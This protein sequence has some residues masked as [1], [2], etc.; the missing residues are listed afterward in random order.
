M[1]G[2]LSG[3]NPNRGQNLGSEH[4]YG[5][6]RAQTPANTILLFSSCSPRF[7][8]DQIHYCFLACDARVSL[9]GP[10]ATRCRPQRGCS[11]R[12]HHAASVIAA[13]R[14]PAARVSRCRPLQGPPKA[15]TQSPSILR[16]P[17]HPRPVSRASVR[18]PRSTTRS[19]H[20]SQSRTRP[21]H[22]MLLLG[23]AAS[24]VC[25]YTRLRHCLRP[26]APACR[27]ASV[28]YTSALHSSRPPPACAT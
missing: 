14:A 24:R 12:Q 6:L 2:R 20:S 8:A 21:S 13:R 25:L 27:P 15:R 1:T 3:L 26:P 9:R 18:I 11:I 7:L 19:S 5:P 17:T 22:A 16:L 23:P 10:R 28:E 4:R